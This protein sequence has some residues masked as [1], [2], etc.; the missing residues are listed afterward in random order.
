MAVA[1]EVVA[2]ISAGDS[3]RRVADL[4]A[5][6]RALLDRQVLDIPDA[7]R[8]GHEQRFRDE[9]DLQTFGPATESLVARFRLARRLGDD[10]TVDVETA[11]AINRLLA[12]SGLLGDA[13]DGRRVIRGR[14]DGARPGQIVRAYVK[15]MRSEKLLVEAT[16]DASGV[17]E[18][19]YTPPRSARADRETA[20][21]RVAVV[22]DAGEEM[23]ST[24]VIFDAAPVEVAPDLA[25]ELS[26][27]ERLTD[28]LRPLVPD[29]G[30]EEL[31]A[32]DAAFLS[33]ED[34]HRRRADRVARRGSQTG[35]RAGRRDHP[36]GGLL[37]AVPEGD[38]DRALCERRSERSGPLSRPP[39]PRASSPQPFA[40]SST[41]S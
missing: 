4:Q 29:G 34:R 30:F 2:P 25:L 36:R 39:S 15:S 31:T 28:E 12:R 5:A 37:R 7:E 9:T 32:D 35:A 13:D 10:A 8:D 38:P 1:N 3:G 21:L 40:T 22:N 17:Y 18:I 23:A 26:E 20:G 24:P 41:R 6:L 19:T 11:A 27:H 14:V 33:R 16:T